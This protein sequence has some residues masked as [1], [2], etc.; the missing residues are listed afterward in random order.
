MDGCGDALT[1]DFSSTSSDETGLSD[2]A[3]R[4]QNDVLQNIDE[5]S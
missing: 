4:V 1:S 3:P 5:D 2:D